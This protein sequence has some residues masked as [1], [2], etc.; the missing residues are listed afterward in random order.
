MGPKLGH[1]HSGT[2][3][4]ADRV[5]IS[6]VQGNHRINKPADSERKLGQVLQCACTYIIKKEYVDALVHLENTWMF[7]GNNRAIKWQNVLLIIYHIP[8]DLHSI[9]VIFIEVSWSVF[10]LCARGNRFRKMNYLLSSSSWLAAEF[11]ST[12][13]PCYTPLCLSTEFML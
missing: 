1:S 6:W 8:D 5:W 2:E 9:F 12:P 7:K 10:S 4:P 3:F 11:W 13:D